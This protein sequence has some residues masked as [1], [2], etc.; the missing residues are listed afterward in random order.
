[1]IELN[2]SKMRTKGAKDKQK[3]KVK[4]PGLIRQY[5]RLCQELDLAPYSSM[6]SD[7]MRQKVDEMMEVAR[8]TPGSRYY[9]M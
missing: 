7:Q 2:L 4:T 5:Q 6:G 8:K 3:R 9:M 1:M